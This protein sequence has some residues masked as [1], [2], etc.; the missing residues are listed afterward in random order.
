MTSPQFFAADIGAESGK[1]VLGILDNNRL[2]ISEIH[3]FPNHMIQVDDHLFWDITALF[4][5]IIRGLN[6]ALSIHQPPP[7]SIGIDTWGVDFGLLDDKGQLLENPYSYRDHRTDG[8]MEKFFPLISKQNIYEL[9]GIQFLQIN[10]LYQLYSMKLAG[11]PTIEK[12]SSL[13]F[14]AD[15]LNY[16]LTGVKVSEYSLATTSQ[17]YNPMKHGWEEVLMNK[18]G[19]SSHIFQK[20]ILPGNIIGHLKPGLL[21]EQ[22]DKEI[23]VMAVGSHDTASAVVAVPAKGENFAYISSGTWSLVGIETTAPVINESTL[24]MNFTNEGGVCKTIRLLKNVMGLWLLQRC[25]HIWSN[26]SNFRYDELA[27][28]SLQAAPF[29]NLINPDDPSFLNPPDMTKAIFDYCIKTGQPG[30]KDMAASVRCI[31]ESLAMKYHFVINQII[32]LNIKKIDKIHIIGGGSKN[33]ILCQFTA[34]STELTVISGPA[35]ATAAGNIMVQAMALGQVKS[36]AEIRQ[37][38]SNSVET[39]TYEPEQQRDWQDAY[40]RF[41]KITG[42]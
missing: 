19:I 11:S 20:I 2:H 26:N 21:S 6:I 24:A 41:L 29:M 15:L 32:S 17:L 18:A 39:I 16:L 42:H 22:P 40:Q 3:R 13:L 12:A 34:N 7:V 4:K 23:Q 14:I 30:P 38:I 37:I 8:I 10:S 1:C 27:E 36:L 5:E 35:E 9:T 33:K 25:N 31:L 28:M